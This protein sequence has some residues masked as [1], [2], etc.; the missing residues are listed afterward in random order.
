MSV[1]TV[2]D[3]YFGVSDFFF[4][5]LLA[6]L[7]SQQKEIQYTS[8]YISAKFFQHLSLL[9]VDNWLFGIE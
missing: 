2:E 6:K 8:L 7:F 1:R 3:N 9:K 4:K 5:F